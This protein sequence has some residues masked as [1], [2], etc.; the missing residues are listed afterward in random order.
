MGCGSLVLRFSWR[1]LRELT[2]DIDKKALHQ[3]RLSLRGNLTI[4]SELNLVMY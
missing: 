2:K 4:N 3:D 1:H